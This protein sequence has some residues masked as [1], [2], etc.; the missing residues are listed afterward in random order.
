MSM[1]EVEQSRT[2]DDD[3]GCGDGRFPPQ[4]DRIRECWRQISELKAIIAEIIGEIGGPVKTGPILGVVNGT[5][6]A[7]GNVGE[8][9]SASL[10]GAFPA[11]TLSQ[12]L[13]P[14]VLTPGDWQVF[15]EC[16]LWSGETTTTPG[17]VTANAKAKGRAAAPAQYT[18]HGTAGGSF[19]LSPVPPG[20]A[21]I[22]AEIYGLANF[23]SV[24]MAA[25]PTQVNVKQPTLMA[26]TLTTNDMADR[27]NAAGTWQF[28]ISARRMR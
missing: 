15:T 9:L 13:Q 4:L 27:D 22:S 16:L 6:A 26:F 1:I 7:A 21:A 2:W 24:S 14:L 8:V 10:I 18:G 20:V 23:Y 3:C 11:E 12:T 19:E 5:A 17:P 25:Q 28:N